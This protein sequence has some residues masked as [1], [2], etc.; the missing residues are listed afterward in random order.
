MTPPGEGWL[1]AI[2]IYVSG[3]WKFLESRTAFLAS[4]TFYEI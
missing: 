2:L 1:L 4:A 3:P